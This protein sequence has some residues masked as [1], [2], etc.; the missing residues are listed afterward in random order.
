MI[1]VIPHT[2]PKPIKLDASEQSLATRDPRPAHDLRA[3]FA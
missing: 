3:T 2:S 1:Q